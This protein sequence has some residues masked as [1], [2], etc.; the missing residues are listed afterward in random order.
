M[1]QSGKD[2]HNSKALKHY[3]KLL[4][5]DSDKVNY[6]HHSKRNNFKN[7]QLYDQD[8]VN[9]LL[10]MSDKLKKFTGT[11]ILFLF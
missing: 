9:R 10:A 1:K 6:L 11:I 4:L 7:A 5:R 8:V 2:P 3:W